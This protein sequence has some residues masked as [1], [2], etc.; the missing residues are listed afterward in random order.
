MLP[1]RLSPSTLPF[2]HT[3][4]HAGKPEQEKRKEVV[5]I[6]EEGREYSQEKKKN[7]GGLLGG[8]RI[9]NLH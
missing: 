4:V 5:G 9:T 3:G 6:Q 8:G 2:L 7:Q 1:A